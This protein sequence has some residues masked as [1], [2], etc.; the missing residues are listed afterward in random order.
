MLLNAFSIDLEDYFHTEVAAQSV[1]REDWNQRPSR[2]ENTVPRLLDMLDETDNRATVFV[3]GW[4]A[5]KYP[6]LI[7]RIASRGHEIACHSYR[8]QAVFRMSPASFHHDTLKAKRTIED[9]TGLVVSGYRAPCFSITPGTEWAFD[10]LSKLDFRYDSSVNPVHHG[11]YGNAGS[12]WLPHH[13]GSAGLLEIPIAVWR[14]GGVNLPVGGGAYL[15]LLPFWY[16]LAGLRHVNRVERRPATIY[17]HPWE[18]DA[19]QP[20][21]HL[22]MLS[23]IRQTWGTATMEGRLRSMLQQF[24]FAP[25]AEVYS[26]AMV[27]KSTADELMPALCSP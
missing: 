4:V 21:L 11:F 20:D 22:P 17:M 10:V 13:V 18:M 2:L 9:A 5:A 24:R 26:T 7:R 3:L 8:H 6:A 15:R 23:H 27:S 25:L 16:S 1:D 19:E 12:P 14:M